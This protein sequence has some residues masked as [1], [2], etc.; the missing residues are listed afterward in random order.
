MRFFGIRTN[1]D[2]F[3]A[4]LTLVGTKP[5]VRLYIGKYVT[6]IEVARPESATQSE[7]L[8]RGRRSPP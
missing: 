7:A 2:K 3:Q 5:H 4:L 6:E 8:F 1:G